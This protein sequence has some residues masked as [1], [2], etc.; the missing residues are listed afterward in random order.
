MKTTSAIGAGAALMAFMLAGIGLAAEGGTLFERIG[1]KDATFAITKDLITRVKADPRIAKKFARSDE[2]RLQYSISGYLCIV[3]D[4]DCN[5]P[6]ESLKNA[7]Q[8]LGVTA[9]E[10]DA[11]MED[12]GAALDERKIVDPDRAAVLKA[13][14]S[15][16]ATVV[17][18]Q[19]K[20]T[21]TDLP[22]S[23][24]PAPPLKF[25]EPA[26]PAPAPEPAPAP[27]PAP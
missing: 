24:R 6:G 20:T 2:E 11:F 23:F 19:A 27:A 26:A 13:L 7:H 21:G 15:A 3:L 22:A 5:Y 16:R 8:G 1:G 4:G 25:A 14:A 10:F 12:L 9:G 17:E 18:S